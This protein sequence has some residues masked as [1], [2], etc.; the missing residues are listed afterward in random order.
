MNKEI[1]SEQWGFKAKYFRF[2]PERVWWG[3]LGIR[4]DFHSSSFQQSSQWTLALP[5][6]ICY[7]ASIKALLVES[8]RGV[9]ASCSGLR[10]TK[11]KSSVSIKKTSDLERFIVCSKAYAW[12]VLQPNGKSPAHD[13]KRK[14]KAQWNI[15]PLGKKPQVRKEE[16]DM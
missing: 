5:S 13:N 16:G 8:S 3:H 12:N 1:K 10:K 6:A 15:I 11:Y 4:R 2:S 7:Q 9:L 14:F